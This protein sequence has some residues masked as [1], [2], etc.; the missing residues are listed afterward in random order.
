MFSGGAVP[1][2]FLRLA[3][4]DIQHEK[5]DH[6]VEARNH[7]VGVRVQLHVAGP[8]GNLAVFL[9]LRHIAEEIGAR[10]RGHRTFACDV[11][12]YGLPEPDARYRH[13]DSYGEQPVRR[14][15]ETAYPAHFREFAVLKA[16]GLQIGQP[17]LL[18][19]ELLF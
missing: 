13:D 18:A 4:R 7:V 17:E 5:L 16:R 6:L 15:D 3:L 8:D 14:F 9:D 1:P 10:R 12:T 2:L 11:K 19:L